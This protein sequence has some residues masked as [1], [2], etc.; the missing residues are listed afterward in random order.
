M[1]DIT[2]LKV[3]SNIFIIGSDVPNPTLNDL[4]IIS[5]HPHSSIKGLDSLEKFAIPSQALLD[6]VYNSPETSSLT[7]DLVLTRSEGN[8]LYCSVIAF[9]TQS[10]VR[11]YFTISY[12]PFY[13]LFRLF[14][15]CAFLN[16]SK[17]INILRI[18][19]SAQT[20]PSLTRKTI[21]QNST[22]TNVI[23]FSISNNNNLFSNIK[24][25]E[26]LFDSTFNG[27]DKEYE[28]FLNVFFNLDCTRFVEDYLPNLSSDANE[29][30]EEAFKEFEEYLVSIMNSENNH[31]GAECDKTVLYTKEIIFGLL[32][33]GVP[34][35]P[36]GR[37]KVNFTLPFPYYSYPQNKS[38][39]KNENSETIEK[40]NDIDGFMDY[41][42][43][44]VIRNK[45][46]IKIKKFK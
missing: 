41:L 23:N 4:K 42:F 5:G 44:T 1:S 36:R 39:S 17:K 30:G 29:E 40:Y 28:D 14:L 18:K 20:N 27:G 13:S 26:E 37:I 32:L 11:C 3:I 34:I 43:E 38:E 21:L 25:L 8:R 16:I 10:K 6:S 22:L 24:E 19:N 31:I 33:Q 2:P 45:G 12:W 7:Y 35:T 9:R 46:I 15:K